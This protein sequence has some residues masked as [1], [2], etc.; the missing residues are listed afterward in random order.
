MSLAEQTMN[1]ESLSKTQASK[2]HSKI[3]DMLGYLFRIRERMQA[4]GFPRDDRLLMSVERAYDSIHRLT[5]ELHY[6]SCDGA[7]RRST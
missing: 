6:L 5:V 1:R 4:R 3:R 2:L 7:G